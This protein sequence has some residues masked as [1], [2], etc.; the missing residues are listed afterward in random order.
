MDNSLAP[1]LPVLHPK[2][3]SPAEP[4]TKR[5][6][7]HKIFRRDLPPLRPKCHLCPQ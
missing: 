1:P 3:D 5:L 6:V 7:Y 4:E 2:S